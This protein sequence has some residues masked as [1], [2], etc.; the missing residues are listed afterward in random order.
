MKYLKRFESVV[1]KDTKINIIKDIV[2]VC[3]FPSSL[4]YKFDKKLEVDRDSDIYYEIEHIE[5]YDEGVYWLYGTYKFY[6]EEETSIY[7]QR[8][9]K[10]NIL[11]IDKI[12][13]YLK[14]NHP[15]YD[16]LFSGNDM[17]L[18]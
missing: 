14:N 8:L 17:G 7:S 13:E 10:A 3:F 1:D 9:E 5:R 16:Y 11:I 18:L 2:D 6:D 4:F 15:E 12:Y